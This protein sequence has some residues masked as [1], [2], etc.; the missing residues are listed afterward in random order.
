MKLNFDVASYF[1]EVFTNC[2]N[3]QTLSINTTAK[4]Y[5]TLQPTAL[6]AIKNTLK[7][8]KGIQV[9]CLA[10][11][12][13]ISEKFLTE[14]N[15]HLGA[16]HLIDKSNN[17][18][19]LHAFL[20]TQRNFLSIVCFGFWVGAEAFKTI[21]LMPH[22]TTIGLVVSAQSLVS[23][24]EAINFPQNLLVSDFC[25]YYSGKNDEIHE[26]F[27]KTCPNAKDLTINLMN[28]RIADFVS[29]NFKSLKNLDMFRFFAN[30]VSN[31]EF[32]LKLKTLTCTDWVSLSTDF[33]ADQNFKNLFEEL[34]GKLTRT[35]RPKYAFELYC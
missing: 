3:L 19:G 12:S 11:R 30:K 28:D 32:F 1:Q 17:V 22:L 34:K 4:K 9:L 25:L 21:L 23:E 18:P 6:D 33:A 5:L 13:L 27:L 8:N 20:K 14:A 29:E 7:T 16:L 31:K 26:Y 10:G 15:L 35:I 24:S 2:R